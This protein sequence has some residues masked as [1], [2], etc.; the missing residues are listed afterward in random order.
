[1]MENIRGSLKLAKTLNIAVGWLHCNFFNI[2][3]C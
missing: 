1:M 2:A 3:A